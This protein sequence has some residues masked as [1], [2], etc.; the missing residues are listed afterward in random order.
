M[1]TKHITAL[2]TFV[3]TF[4]LSAFLVTLLRP[5]TVS[6]TR[7]VIVNRGCS[8]TNAQRITQLLQQDIANANIPREFSSHQSSLAASTEYYV[9]AS[10]SLSYQDLPTDFQTAWQNHMRAWRNQVDL[11]NTF[12][13][14]FSQDEET[15]KMS[16]R[17]TEEIN[18]TWWEVLRIAKKYGSLIPEGAY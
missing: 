4:A 9:S 18:R 17:N 11:Y 7:K 3:I 5:P 2:V 8:Y 13:D 10:E 1:K 16:A 12:E 15:L 14:D 6:Q